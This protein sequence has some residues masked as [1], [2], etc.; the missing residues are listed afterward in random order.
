MADYLKDE[1]N[2]R[3]RYDLHTIEEYLDTVKMFQE[4]YQKSLASDEL[5]DLSDEE[6]LRNITLTLGQHRFVIR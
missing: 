3:E 4:V 2:Y 5:K 6:K 1:Q